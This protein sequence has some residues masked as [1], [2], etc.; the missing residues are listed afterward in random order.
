M[1]VINRIILVYSSVFGIGYIKCA[2]GTISSLA[3]ILIWILFVPNVFVFQIFILIVM[4][5]VSILFSSVAQNIY[6]TKD[7]KRIVIDEVAGTWFS[8]AFLPKTIIFLL[9][10]F[11]LFRFFDI[12]KPLFIKNSQ[13]LSGGFGITIDDIIA[14]IFTNVILQCVRFLLDR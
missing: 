7:D 11:L 10:G 13:N 14:G 8:I 1:R 4:F 9:S 12:R 5:L 3:G 2:P 6:N